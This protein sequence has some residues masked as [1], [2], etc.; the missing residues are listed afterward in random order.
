MNQ[1]NQ[2]QGNYYGGGYRPPQKKP[3]QNVAVWICVGLLSVVLI[4]GALFVGVFLLKNYMH[5]PTAG[6]VPTATATATAEPSPQA[7]ETPAPTVGGGSY[8][9]SQNQS[10]VYFVNKF[11]NSGIYVRTEPSKQSA[12]LLYIAQ[13][14]T[15]VRLRYLGET[16]SYDPVEQLN[17]VWYQVE[18]P[19]GT[20]GFVRSDVVRQ[21]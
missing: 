8:Y 11:S 18:T 20:V 17:Y 5:T 2:G 3:N 14:D 15:N 10:G 7:S 16:V 13:G 1:M 9:Y 12:K 6:P 19:N 4:G 21:W